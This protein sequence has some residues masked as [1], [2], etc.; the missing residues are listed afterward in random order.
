MKGNFNDAP[1]VQSEH[2]E[3]QERE[4]VNFAGGGVI[5]RT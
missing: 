3:N 2:G 5:K 4:D 1:Y